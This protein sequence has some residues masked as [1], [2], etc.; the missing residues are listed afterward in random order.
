MKNFKNVLSIEANVVFHG[1]GA[2]NMDGSSQKH[3]LQKHELFKQDEQCGKQSYD[4]VA[5]HKKCFMEDENGK[6]CFKYKVDNHCIRHNMYSNVLPA[7]N[8]N[9]ITLPKVFFNA[10]ASPEL[11]A[12]GYMETGSLGYSCVQKRSIFNISSAIADMQPAYLVC[13]ETHSNSGNK[14][15]K[16]FYHIENIG[17]YDYI[18]TL[19]LDLTEAQFIS[20]DDL[21]NRC[22]VRFNELKEQNCSVT[23]K[24]IFFKSLKQNFGGYEDTPTD[25]G[26]YAL[27]SS[28]YGDHFA[29]EGIKLTPKMV[30]I[31]V[32]DVIK[33]LIDIRINKNS[34]GGT[35]KFKEMN[36]TV[37]MANNQSESF[38]ICKYDDIKDYFFEYND[39]YVEVD[40]DLIAER[41][42][43]IELYKNAEQRKEKQ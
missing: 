19:F 12:K 20:M 5:F 8:D 13:M 9:Y 3:F 42:H 2:I 6:T 23:Y 10:L 4:N 43:C 30:N 11:I 7:K 18:S 21:Y 29:E 25:T 34:N 39:T 16:S 15:N 38:T 40:Q 35:F 14:D 37:H 1:N 36:V 22:A 33:R 26:F 31:L 41:E 24:E 28:I 17:S 32:H 27:S